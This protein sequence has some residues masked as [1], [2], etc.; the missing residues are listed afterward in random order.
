M[1]IYGVIKREVEFLA[2]LE[3]SM[4]FVGKQEL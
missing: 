1:D 3:L 2:H 4:T